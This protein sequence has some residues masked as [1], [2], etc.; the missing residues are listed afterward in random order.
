MSNSLNVLEAK[1]N[2]MGNKL[3]LLCDAL[4]HESFPNVERFLRLFVKQSIAIKFAIS[5]GK[6]SFSSGKFSSS[7][8]VVG[9]VAQ[10]SQG[11]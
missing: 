8:M 3:D 1:L 6:F 10:I 9:C 5:S 2:Q 7:S 4:R 11:S